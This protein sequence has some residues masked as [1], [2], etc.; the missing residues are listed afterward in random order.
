MNI[1]ELVKT[2]LNSYQI[3]IIALIFMTMNHIY[4]FTLGKTNMSTSIYEIF[5]RMA[6]PAFLYVAVYG[7]R[8]SSNKVRYI[9]RLYLYNIAINF[10][11]Y[12]LTFLSKG[13]IG[14][15]NF[16]VIS[17][18]N[19]TLFYIYMIENIIFYIKTDYI[20]TIKYILLSIIALVIPTI[21]L[22]LFPEKIEILN[23]FIPS[24]FTVAF[25]P[26][27]VIM[28]ILWYFYNKKFQQCFILV[29]FSLLSIIGTY[30]Y[31]SLSFFIFLDFFNATEK[32]IILFLPFIL[33]FNGEKGKS[34]KLFFYLYYPLHIY[35]LSIISYLFF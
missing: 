34:H 18:I 25:S 11:L 22:I 19:Y 26:L 10:G 27:F 24:I 4:D 30:L 5:G 21:L 9:I 7:F 33:L 16:S 29:I 35:M 31:S 15:Y 12:I 8:Y 32:Y 14:Y 1:K 2:G 13:N 17:T 28:G 6:F 20:K 23:V 3:K